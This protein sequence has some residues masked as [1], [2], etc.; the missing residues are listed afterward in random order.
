MITSD[1]GSTPLALQRALSL[2]LAFLVM[3]LRAQTLRVALI[4]GATLR[5]RHNMIALRS[6]LYAVLDQTHGT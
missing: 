6:K 2:C 4:I 5:Q 3:T 1:A